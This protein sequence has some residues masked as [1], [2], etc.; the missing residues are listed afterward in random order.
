MTLQGYLHLI[1][2]DATAGEGL[3][4]SG[5][6]FW[7]FSYDFVYQGDLGI[8]DWLPKKCILHGRDE[9]KGSVRLCRTS[10]ISTYVF[11]IDKN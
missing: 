10:C 7:L 8:F 11:Q 5:L 1:G 9:I 4:D 6:G 3:Q 2:G